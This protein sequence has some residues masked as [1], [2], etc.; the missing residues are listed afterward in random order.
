MNPG[1]S[2]PHQDAALHSPAPP[3]LTPGSP[4][5][6]RVGAI[7]L[8]IAGNLLL[9]LG[10]AATGM[11]MGL[12]L[13]GIDRARGD[14]PAIA[15]GL[16]AISFYGT[17][18][19]GAPFFGVQSDRFGPRRFMI[20]GP[21]CGGLAIQLIGWPSTLVG[22][23]ALLAPMIIGRMIEGLSTATSAPSTLSFL[24]AA[25]MG[26]PGLRGR[27]MAWYEMAT[28]VGIGGGFV[29]GGLFW[30]QL[31]HASFAAVT[32]VYGL[33]LLAF[34]RVPSGHSSHLSLGETGARHRSSPLPRGEAGAGRQGA[35]SEGAPPPA[36]GSALLRVLRRPRVLR[37]VPA[38]LL[39]NT[40]LGVWFTHSTFQL[41]GDQQAGQ[42]LSGAFTGTSI[43]FAF[44]LVSG[45]FILGIYLWGLAIG[46]RRK[47]DIMLVTISG[48]YLLCGAL[49]ALNHVPPDS[50]VPHSFLVALFIGGVAI[51][52]GFTPAAL[53][54]LADISEEMMEHRGAVM[55]LYSVM[56]GLGQLAGGS[57]GGPF[58]DLGGFDGLILLTSLLGTGSLVAVLALRRFEGETAISRPRAR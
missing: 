7:V 41:A 34:W 12:L 3:A 31:G 19:L 35:P 9:R 44:A 43:G 52:A 36:E 8:C 27:V 24:G 40:V 15:V 2:P 53:A 23:P 56:L 47:T 29:A 37:F 26:A 46:T 42:Q 21:I 14:V 1:P 25:T 18:L 22:W 51:T 30:D 38:W 33:S 10:N 50:A 16:L 54:Y 20:I 13:A 39:V 28:V 55:G 11:L 6:T 4:A 17:E 5:Q 58:A 48:I 57:L 49:L 45:A 32:A